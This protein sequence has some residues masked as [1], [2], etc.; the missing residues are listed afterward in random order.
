MGTARS[1]KD[2]TPDRRDA[3]DIV[4]RKTLELKR[5]SLTHVKD[6]DRRSLFVK[7]KAHKNAVGNPNRL[8]NFEDDFSQSRKT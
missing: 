3:L 7:A 5:L 2:A 4:V 6:N 8:L 1:L